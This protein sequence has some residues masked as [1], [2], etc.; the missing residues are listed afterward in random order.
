MCF[1]E[2]CSQTAPMS[3]A[4][5]IRTCSRSTAS[6]P[7][8]TFPQPCL[9]KRVHPLDRHLHLQVSTESLMMQFSSS[10]IRSE[11]CYVVDCLLEFR[12]IYC[13]CV[14][15]KMDGKRTLI[16]SSI[17]NR[18]IEMKKNLKLSKLYVKIIQPLWESSF[19]M[20]AW[21]SKICTRLVIAGKRASLSRTESADS[22]H[23]R[24][25]FPTQTSGEFSS[26]SS[27]SS[28]PA[29]DPAADPFAPSS[30]PRQHVQEGDRFASFDKVSITSS[31]SPSPPP[32]SQ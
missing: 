10:S 17:S 13:L 1:L 3:S 31:S 22:F 19:S 24:G 30:P 27:S 20:P 14:Y 9:P 8:R 7:T 29:K 21:P 15:K 26:S 28:L 16:N 32:D 25:H 23:R 18:N 2:C 6:P 12:L 11:E 5:T 4:S